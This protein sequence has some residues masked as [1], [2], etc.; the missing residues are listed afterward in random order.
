[1]TIDLH[2]VFRLGN[3][4]SG[5]DPGPNQVNGNITVSRDSAL[6]LGFL[7]TINGDVTCLDDES[8]LSGTFNQPA[9][10]KISCTGFSA[11]DGKGGGGNPNKP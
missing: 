2:S 11:E 6:S 7:V 10:F 3:E 1:M 8:S 4:P 9:K 5:G